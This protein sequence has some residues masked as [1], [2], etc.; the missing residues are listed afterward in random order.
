M[1]LHWWNPD[2]E[3]KSSDDEP[4]ASL[5]TVYLLMFS[6]LPSS[7]EQ[8]HLSQDESLGAWYPTHSMQ[9]SVSHCFL[10]DYCHYISQRSFTYDN[11]K[12]S[13]GGKDQEKDQSWRSRIL[14]WHRTWWQWL[15][16]YFLITNFQ[17]TSENW[18]LGHSFVCHFSGEFWPLQ[19]RS[20]FA[21]GNN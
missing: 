13:R 1:H 11:P 17:I 8:L 10:Q 18:K 14:I 21:K 9:T 7:K 19:R 20:T 4:D 6:L 2:S 16:G 5:F 3:R 15:I 12:T